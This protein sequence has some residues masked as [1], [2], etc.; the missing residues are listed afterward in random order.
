MTVLVEIQRVQAPL[1]FLV[2]FGVC[3]IQRLQ[4]RKGARGIELA[5]SRSL[6]GPVDESRF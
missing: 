5:R 1:S 2:N 3:Q 6:V 4:S